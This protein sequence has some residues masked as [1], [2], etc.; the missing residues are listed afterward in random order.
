MA[1]CEVCKK[2]GDT[3]KVGLGDKST[4]AYKEVQMCPRCAVNGAAVVGAMGGEVRVVHESAGSSD[5]G[6]AGAWL[7]AMA[8]L[9]TIGFAISWLVS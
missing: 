6:G 9:A 4:G 1:Q 5:S 7:A 8:V 2:Y 3:G